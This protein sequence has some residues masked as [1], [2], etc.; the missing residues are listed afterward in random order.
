MAGRRGETETLWVFYGYIRLKDCA[1]VVRYSQAHNPLCFTSASG[2][3]SIHDVVCRTETIL[4]NRS[5]I[6]R[7]G[8]ALGHEPLRN[9]EG[10]LFQAVRIAVVVVRR[11]LEPAL[12]KGIMATTPAAYITCW[13]DV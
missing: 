8:W 6:S 10:P 13:F 7:V 12:V 2:V 4:A 3:E 5:H 11:L 9:A 1:Q